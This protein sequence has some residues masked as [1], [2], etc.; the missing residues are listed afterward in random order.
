MSTF[1]QTC[2]V[3][4]ATGLIVLIAASLALVLI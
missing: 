2:F 1:E 4:T 3:V